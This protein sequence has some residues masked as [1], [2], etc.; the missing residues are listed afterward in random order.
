MLPNFPEIELLWTYLSSETGKENWTYCVS[1]LHK[2]LYQEMLRCTRAL[3]A[4]KWARVSGTFYDAY[5]NLCYVRVTM[6]FPLYIVN[7]LLKKVISF[8][9]V[10]RGRRLKFCLT[11]RCFWK[12]RLKLMKPLKKT[13]GAKIALI[14][15]F[16]SRLCVASV[17]T[18]RCSASLQGR[19][20]QL[21][22]VVKRPA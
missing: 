22:I 3:T 21:K 6:L 2:T 13:C 9:K 19:A 17:G 12:G 7:S 11:H 20:A 16:L 18:S 14:T 5:K 15:G 1:V 4:G 10:T 8:L